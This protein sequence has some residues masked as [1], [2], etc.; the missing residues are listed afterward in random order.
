MVERESPKFLV[1]V[2]FPPS[3]FLGDLA[4]GDCVVLSLGS[5]MVERATVNRE[6]VGSSP[7]RD[8]FFFAGG[9]E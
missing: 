6:V 1:W 8:V 7:I 2:R 9:G 5:S 3:L 4:G